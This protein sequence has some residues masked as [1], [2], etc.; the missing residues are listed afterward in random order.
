[1]P[2]SVFEPKAEPDALVVW[3]VPSETNQRLPLDRHAIAQVVAN[4]KLG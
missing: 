3:T 1:M 4:L 2:R